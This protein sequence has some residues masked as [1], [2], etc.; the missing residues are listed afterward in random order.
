MIEYVRLV[1][2]GD[3]KGR[4]HRVTHQIVKNVQ[5][6]TCHYI[7]RISPTGFIFH[8]HCNKDILLFI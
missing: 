5:S 2:G 3:G 6:L 7:K 8:T 1:N 4:P